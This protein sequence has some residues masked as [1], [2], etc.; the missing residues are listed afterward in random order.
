VDAQLLV[1]R[2]VRAAT[3]LMPAGTDHR[4]AALAPE[5]R[6]LVVDRD[7]RA[8]ALVAAAIAGTGIPANVVEAEDATSALAAADDS[9]FDCLCV[10]DGM[11]EM[12]G[13]EM[14]RALRQRGVTAPILVVAS[15]GDEEESAILEAG[16]TDYLPK[17]DL[18]AESV[19]R[20]LRHV[21]RVVRAEVV[22]SR[23]LEV[24]VAAARARDEILQIVAHDLRGPLNSIG[25]ACGGLLEEPISAEGLACVTAIEHAAA[26]AERLIEDLLEVTR[27]E[28]G[29]L[30][31]AIGAIDVRGLV[32]EVCGDHERAAE[33]VGSTIAWAVPEGDAC[34]L[35]DRDRLHQA[36]S[37]L[38]GNA[39][40][41]ARGTPITLSVDMREAEVAFVVADAGPGISATALPHIFDRYWQG[42]DRH[43]GAGLGL[44]IANGIVAAHGGSIAATSQA[45]RGARF[46]ICLPRSRCESDLPSMAPDSD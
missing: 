21:L 19:A 10:D 8:R 3:H 45:G 31:L 34:V 26:R 41:H 44:A 28:S 25:L 16:A 29:H 18:S 12:S 15:G 4:L 22:S 23:A 6:V 40:V 9:T 38:I 46:E 24:A 13:R 39:L 11:P 30:E 32:I 14:V 1:E 7:A 36:L 27:I 5:L 2:R 33:A 17:R 42:R 20:R 37:N 35:A 43:G